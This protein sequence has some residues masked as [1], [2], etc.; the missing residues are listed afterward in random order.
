MKPRSHTMEFSIP[1]CDPA[2]AEKP[3]ELLVD[4]EVF[5]EFYRR[6]VRPLWTYLVRVSGNDTLADDLVQE[7]YLR[8]LCARAP[9]EAGEAACRRYLFRIGTN[10]LRDHWRHPKTHS[11][12]D[13]PEHDLPAVSPFKIECLD[14]QLFLDAALARLRQAE[15][16]LLWLAHAEGMSYREISE[17][18]GFGIAR[19]RLALFRARHKLARALRQQ[20]IKRGVRR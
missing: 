3:A 12:E 7:S 4:E 20:M 2:A 8:F 9:W 15:R 17:I 16:Q 13:V 14:A 5:A 11:L 18:T 10:L 1:D 6:T 19:I